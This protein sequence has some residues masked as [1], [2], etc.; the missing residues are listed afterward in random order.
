MALFF[1]RMEIL[2]NGKSPLVNITGSL[3]HEIFFCLI[4][5]AVFSEQG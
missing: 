5:Y 1:G 4:V 2:Y 3:F